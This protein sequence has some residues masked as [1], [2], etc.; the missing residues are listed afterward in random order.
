VDK[1]MQIYLIVNASRS[2][3]QFE[4]QHST[5]KIKPEKLNKQILL[6]LK[7]TPVCFDWPVD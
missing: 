6:I 2:P 1:E 3:T 7:S 4:S 5:V